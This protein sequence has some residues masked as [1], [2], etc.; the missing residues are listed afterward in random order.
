M[1]ISEKIKTNKNK[2]EQDKAQYN[3]DRQTA[4]ISALSSG[5]V[6]KFE[7]LTDKDVLPGKD[8]LEK[9]ATMKTFKY[10]QLD[11]ELKAQTDIAKK[12]YQKLEDTYDFDK[13]IKKEKPTRENYRSNIKKYL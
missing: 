12:Q 11:K 7:F 3:L 6:S 13:I 4:R 8:L 2:I 5:Y 10:L 9:V 1:S